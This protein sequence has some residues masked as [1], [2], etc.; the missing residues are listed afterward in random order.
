MSFYVN[1]PYLSEQDTR[2]EDNDDPAKIRRIIEIKSEGLDVIH[3]IQRWG[4]TQSVAFELE[5]AFIDYFGLKELSNLVKGHHSDRGMV[6]ADYLEQS[7]KLD[8]FVDYPNSPK[9]ILIKIK[10]YW[11]N[12][13]GNSI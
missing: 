2:S 7:F 8:S 13:N 6:S 12:E 10:N 4:L 3:M 1:N 9:F 11:I 5:A